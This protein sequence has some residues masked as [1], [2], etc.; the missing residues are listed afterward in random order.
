M[1]DVIPT[2]TEVATSKLVCMGYA[3]SYDASSLLV[4]I[5][6]LVSLDKCPTVDKSLGL[7]WNIE[8]GPETI[9]KPWI[10]SLMG[11]FRFQ[12]SLKSIHGYVKKRVSI[13]LQGR[14]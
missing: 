8:T 14:S 6:V 3:S 13:F 12:F 4:G 10:F 1:V 9:R 2:F 5:A 7:F 11:G